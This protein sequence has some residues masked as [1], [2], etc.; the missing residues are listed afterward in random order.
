MTLSGHPTVSVVIPA[1]NAARFIT[2]AVT[3]V[4]SGQAGTLPDDTMLDVAEVIVVDDR[5][6]DDTMAVLHGL[7]TQ[8]PR[9]K[10][11]QNPR[12]LGP[13]GSRNAGVAAATGDWIAL[14]DADDA[15]APGRLLRMV[16]AAQAAGVDILAD[17]PVLYDMAAGLAAP[18][19]QQLPAS[20]RTDILRLA[21]FLRPDPETG[22]DLGLLKP[23]FRRRLVV[24]G[25]WHYPDD[26]RHGEDFAL[27]FDLVAGGEK[28]ALLRE[29]LYVFS[30]RIGAVSGSY[31][32]GSVTNVNYRTIAADA[33]ILAHRYSAQPDADAEVIA[34]L[35]TRK[36]RALRQNRIH[37]WTL[38]RKREIRRLRQW[39]QHDP[40][41]RTEILHIIA[42]KLTGHRGLPD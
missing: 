32:P 42:A 22:L 4:L 15:F 25:L 13:A 12:N 34:L 33:E 26:I 2:R 28:F 14:L 38:P 5:S 40:R 29:A 23:V 27:Y 31:S 1:W 18:A 10:L 16:G 7:A 17:L 19:A 24:E 3:S 8:H 37:G 30:T 35:A 39:L 6:T 11:L 41:N 9:I 20:G 36:D 21:D